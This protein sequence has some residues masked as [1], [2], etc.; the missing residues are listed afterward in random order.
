MARIRKER[1][2]GKPGATPPAMS[3]SSPAVDDDPI[4]R[5]A[6]P[7]RADGLPAFDR[8]RD[9]NKEKLRQWL[10]SPDVAKG[11]GVT[12]TPLASS[13][14]DALPPEIVEAA[15]VAFGRIESMLLGWY[16]KAPANVVAAIVPFS[17]DETRVLMPLTS[18]V[19]NKYAGGLLGKYGDEVALATMVVMMTGAKLQ[20]LG[21]VM[22]Q[23]RPPATPPPQT[24]AEPAE[25]ARR[26]NV[27][28]MEPRIVGAELPTSG[29][30]SV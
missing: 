18:K 24:P 20:A 5:I 17:P 10:T 11:L 21:Q 3:A 26:D 30:P 12:S 13:A 9:D 2:A 7:T 15:I 14:D 23:A 4:T 22:A 6:I 1:E 16:T 8:M 29:G 19:L 27:V 25:P 28:P